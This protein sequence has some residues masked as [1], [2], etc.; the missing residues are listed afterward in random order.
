MEEKTKEERARRLKQLIEEL[1]QGTDYEVVKNSFLSE[2]QNVSPSELAAAEGEVIRSGV[3]VKEV[4]NLCDL[5]AAAFQ[6]GIKAMVKARYH[7]NKVTPISGIARR[8]PWFRAIAK[9]HQDNLKRTAK[10]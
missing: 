6:D 5:H 9:Q 3:P 4:Q 10:Q 2:F 1:H 7:E 8:K